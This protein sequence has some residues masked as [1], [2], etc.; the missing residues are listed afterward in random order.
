MTLP[1]HSV[2]SLIDHTYLPAFPLPSEQDIDS[3]LGVLAQEANEHQFAAVCVR[4]EHA[5]KMR[6]LLGKTSSVKLAVVIGFPQQKVQLNDEKW[7]PTIGNSPLEK[8]LKEIEQAKAANATELDVV[9]DVFAFQTAVGL[10]KPNSLLGWLEEHRKAADGMAIK[11]IIET[12][13]LTPEQIDVATLLC[14]QAGFAMVKTSTGYVQ[15]GQGATV[16]NIKRMAYQLE[17]YHQDHPEE[18]QLGIKASG[19][20]RTPEE[21]KA[22]IEAGAS[23]IG[24]SNGVA[25]LETSDKA[26]QSV[27]EY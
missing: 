25:L 2:A 27:S 14:A 20:V 22:M 4:P 24:T 3:K 13:I 1:L 12:D 10:G 23:R 17:R 26:V 15:E 6:Q 5:L 8:R 21:A 7:S 19:G 18:P 16:E 11:L 9:L